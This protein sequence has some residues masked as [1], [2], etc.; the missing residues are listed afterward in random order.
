MCVRFYL[1]VQLLERSCPERLNMATHTRL[2][3]SVIIPRRDYQEY[4]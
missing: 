3:I 4:Q 2:K 1:A